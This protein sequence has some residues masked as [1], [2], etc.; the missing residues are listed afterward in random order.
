MRSRIQTA[1]LRGVS[2]FELQ[3]D[4]KALKAAYE[5][6]AAEYPTSEWVT[7]AYPYRLL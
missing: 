3:H 7:R 1:D 6:L 4:P 5:R 2:S